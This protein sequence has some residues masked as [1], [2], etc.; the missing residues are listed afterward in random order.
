M[1]F[2]TC[3]EVTEQHINMPFTIDLYYWF[4]ILLLLSLQYND[5]LNVAES[6][7]P[8]SRNVAIGIYGLILYVKTCYISKQASVQTPLLNPPFA[9]SCR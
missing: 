8:V 9:W 2:Y 6:K 4:L 3:T 1:Q 5:I 7:K